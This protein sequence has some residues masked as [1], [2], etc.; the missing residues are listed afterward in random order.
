MVI[1]IIAQSLGICGM[2]MNIL[3]YQRK[4]QRS[5]IFMQLI[6][7]AF[8]SANY[9][10][11]GAMAGAM[12][13]LAAIVRAVVYVKRDRFHADSLAWV[14]GLSAVYAV[15]YALSFL[16]FGTEPTVKKL[17]VE[18]LPVIAMVVSTVSFYL[19]SAGAVRFLGLVGSPLWLTYNI[20]NFAIGGIICEAVA[21]TSI[22]IGIIRYDLKK[23]KRALASADRVDTEQNI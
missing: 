7:A 20:I 8:F 10:L 23:G 22:V 2:I 15:I 12:L 6:G 9:F 14:I 3:S 16:V 1:E 18:L 19:K 11:L 17:I 21:L 4:E 13:N 5:I